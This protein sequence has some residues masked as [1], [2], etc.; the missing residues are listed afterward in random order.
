MSFV[1][2]E[3]HG[4]TDPLATT[5][6]D[7]SEDLLTDAVFGTLRHMAPDLG[8]SRILSAVGVS[9]SKL[10]LEKAEVQMW[11]HVPMPGWPG[12]IIEPDVVVVVGSRVVVFE[13]KLYSPF[14][15]YHDPEDDDAPQFHQLAVQYAAVKSWAAGLRLQPPVMVAVTADTARP[16]SALQ[17]AVQ[18]IRRLTGDP[19]TGLVHWLPWHRIAEMLS[20]LDGLRPNEQTHVNDLLGFMDGRGVRKVFKGFPM[21][22][23]WL[24]AA[25]QRVAGERLYPQIRT[26]FDELTSI[27]DKDHI[28]WS[29][30]AY[31]AMW[32][33]GA[34]NSV[35]KPTDWARS[36]VGAQY[37]PESWPSRGKAGT[38]LSLY[39][40][41]DF[42]DPALEVGLSIPGPGA[43]A[44]QQKWPAFLK[45]L[46]QELSQL[47]DFDLVLDS[48][49]LARPTRTISCADVDEAWLSSVCGQ[50]VNVAHLRLRRRVPVETVTAQQAREEIAT[51]QAA[52]LKCETLWQ[53]FASTSHVTYPEHLD[54]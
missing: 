5:P 21:E 35:S 41:F 39:A 47:D 27:L 6:T 13:A 14:S 46:A 17:Q 50:M 26:F 16:T 54:K 2:A 29:Q 45:P 28:G 25:A 3:I 22:D 10:E 4:K 31:K 42:V 32:L 23:Y 1:L 37:W 53:L 44:A 18:D 11:P 36:F 12:R 38:S 15:Q 43:A 52:C 30:P 48:G 8:L 34:S 40:V 24:M 49:D 33:G 19:G 20:A 51:V 9:A 7:R